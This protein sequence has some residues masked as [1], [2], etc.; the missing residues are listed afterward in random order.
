MDSCLRLF[1]MTMHII[2]NASVSA[3]ISSKRGRYR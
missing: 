3:W 1:R 2:T